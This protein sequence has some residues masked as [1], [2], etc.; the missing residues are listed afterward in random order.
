MSA[1][2]AER[3][4]VSRVEHEPVAGVEGVPS[5]IVMLIRIFQVQEITGRVTELLDALLKV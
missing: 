2:F 4:I 5:P 3:K 1:A